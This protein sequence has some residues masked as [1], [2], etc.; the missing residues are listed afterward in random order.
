[1]KRFEIG[2][3]LYCINILGYSAALKKDIE[4]LITEVDVLSNSVL[5][6]VNSKNCLKKWFGINRF[7]TYDEYHKPKHDIEFAKKLSNL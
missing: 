4:Y 5:V 6:R 2:D 7:I 3:R 1:M